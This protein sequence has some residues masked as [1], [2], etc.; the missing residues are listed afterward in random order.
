MVETELRVTWW[1]IS[2]RAPALT[3]RFRTHPT[4][5]VPRVEGP[6]H[7]GAPSALRRPWRSTNLPW[8]P[9]PRG[10][11]AG[12]GA[13]AAASPTSALGRWVLAVPAPGPEHIAAARPR[14][15]PSTGCGPSPCRGRARLPRPVRVGHGRLPGGVDVLHP[16]RVPDHLAAAAGVGPVVVGATCAGSGAAGSGA[17]CP[18]RGS[19]WRWCVRHG[20]GRHLEHRPAPVAARR[21]ALR[22]GRDHQLALHRPGPLLRHRVHRT[23][24]ARALLEPGDR[25]A[26]LPGAPAAPGRPAGPGR[27]GHRRPQRWCGVR[28]VRV[29][30]VVA[31]LVALGALGAVANGVLAQGSL[32]PRLLRHRTRLAELVG[33]RAAGL[34]DAAAASGARTEWARRLLVGLGVAGPGRDPALWHVATV[35]S[36]WMYPWGLLLAAACTACAHRRG[37]AGRSRSAAVLS[38]GTAAVAGPDQLRRVPAA[39]AGVPVA[40]TGTGR[41]VTLAAVRP[42]HGGDAG[43]GHA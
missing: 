9:A 36:D 37:A 18:P 20:R 39:L 3:R 38:L 11:R 29:G 23:V 5:P 24:T 25:A 16:V 1:G 8:R 40:H 15:P 14:R 27:S 7:R 4:G 17:S 12:P 41:V 22:P 19:R 43:R 33:R 31:V 34:R 21:R 28:R 32:V 30:P 35:A 2:R 26:V 10:R 6:P 42:P 13:A